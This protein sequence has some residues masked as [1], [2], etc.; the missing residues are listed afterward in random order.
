MKVLTCA[1]ALRSLQ[2]FHD[3]ELPVSGQIAV[4]SH[5]DGCGRCAADL[6]ELR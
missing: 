4:S 5:V 1:A 3:G 2:A 6:A